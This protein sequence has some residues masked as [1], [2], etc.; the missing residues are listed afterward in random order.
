VTRIARELAFITRKD[1]GG[2]S[3]M[4]LLLMVHW[5]AQAAAHQAAHPKIPF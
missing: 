1:I 3:R 2:L 4:P 5:H